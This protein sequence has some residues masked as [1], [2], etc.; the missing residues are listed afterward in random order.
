[1][2]NNNIKVKRKEDETQTDYVLLCV[3]LTGFI[4]IIYLVDYVCFTFFFYHPFKWITWV[5]G[6]LSWIS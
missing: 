5:G 6:L 4:F 2:F 1:M 3:K